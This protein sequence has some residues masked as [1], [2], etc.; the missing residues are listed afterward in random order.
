M[1]ET[2]FIDNN[3]NFP[4]PIF[5]YQSSCKSPVIVWGLRFSLLELCLH[6]TKKK[7]LT[8]KQLPPIKKKNLTKDGY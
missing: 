7:I 1:S 8:S 3:N 2:A 4:P 6:R 5:I